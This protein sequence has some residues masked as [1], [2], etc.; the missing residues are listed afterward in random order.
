VSEAR[1]HQRRGK[2]NAHAHDEGREA[3]TMRSRVAWRSAEADSGVVKR[4]IPL[5]MPFGALD[6]EGRPRR[7][8]GE[9][10]PGTH[11][12]W[13]HAVRLGGRNRLDASR[14]FHAGGSQGSSGLEGR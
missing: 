7:E 3:E 5:V 8:S 11:E 1:S 9:R 6:S 10:E 14:V 13:V 12:V 2:K 4:S